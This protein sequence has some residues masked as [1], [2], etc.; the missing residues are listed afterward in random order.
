MFWTSDLNVAYKEGLPIPRVTYRCKGKATVEAGLRTTK[1]L[2]KLV[3]DHEGSCQC[4]CDLEFN[5]KE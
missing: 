3:T 5:E 2:C 1:H 4:I